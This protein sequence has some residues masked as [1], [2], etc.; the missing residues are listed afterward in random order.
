MFS[1][2]KIMEQTDDPN[3]I[4]RLLT[5]MFGFYYDDE[6]HTSVMTDVSKQELSNRLLLF[7]IKLCLINPFR[8]IEAENCI[9][10]VNCFESDFK[11]ETNSTSVD[12]V[13][14]ASLAIVC[15]S[16]LLFCI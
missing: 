3:I 13:F 16:P 11:D 7:A 4:E 14:S 9:C 6:C 15:Y 10:I 5:P 8:F 12:K 2:A 1:R